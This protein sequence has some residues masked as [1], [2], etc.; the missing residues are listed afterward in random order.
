MSLSRSDRLGAV[1]SVVS[2]D[3]LPDSSGLSEFRLD[4]VGVV[5]EALRDQVR[6]TLTER[7]P[8]DDAERAALWRRFAEG[9]EPVGYDP[10]IIPPWA[11]GP[12][13]P[14]FSGWKLDPYRLRVMPGSAMLDGRGL[15]TW[16]AAD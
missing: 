15:L 16:R 3:R 11:D 13:S 7:D 12:E 2:A 4:T 6:R 8:I 1:L 9:P 5:S 10:A 14:A